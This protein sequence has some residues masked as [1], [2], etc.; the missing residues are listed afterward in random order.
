M[1][2]RRGKGSENGSSDSDNPAVLVIGGG[3]YIGAPAMSGLSALRTGSDLVYIVTPKKAAKAIT[4][5]SPHLIKPLRLAKQTSKLSLNL[6][7]KEL[8]K[9]DKL[10]PDDIDTIEFFL[11]KADSVIIGPGLGNDEQTKNAVENIIKKCVKLKMDYFQ[12][13]H[14]VTKKFY[15]NHQVQCEQKMYMDFHEILK[16]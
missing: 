2:F 16:K 15:T 5:F 14:H 4:S 6:I 11:K 7:V 3:P 13:Q 8:K 1:P 9:E 12:I 10:V